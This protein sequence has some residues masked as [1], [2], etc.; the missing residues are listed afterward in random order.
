M[1]QFSKYSFESVNSVRGKG[2]KRGRGV[3]SQG[4]AE[5]MKCNKVNRADA[6]P[7]PA[8]AFDIDALLSASHASTERIIQL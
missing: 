1:L 4:D 3:M 2:K 7:L 8:R 5:K 6:V